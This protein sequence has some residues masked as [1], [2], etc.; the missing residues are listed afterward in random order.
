MSNFSNVF[1]VGRA[2]LRARLSLVAL[3]SLAVL[4]CEHERAS[5]GE[6]RLEIVSLGQRESATPLRA[7]GTISVRGLDHGSHHLVSTSS[8]AGTRT[9]QLASGLYSVTTRTA[10]GVDE[11]EARA[12]PPVQASALL[13]RVDSGRVAVVRV[14]FES[15]EPDVLATVPPD[16]ARSAL[17]YQGVSGLLS[18]PAQ[19]CRPTGSECDESSAGEPRA[20]AHGL[21]VRAVLDRNPF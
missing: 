15:H 17:G 11:L 5:S 8:E 2:R 19:I 12:T 10:L 16:I 4:A 1:D 3:I 18:E 14:R 20:P 9:L 7:R 6:G 13:V 21:P